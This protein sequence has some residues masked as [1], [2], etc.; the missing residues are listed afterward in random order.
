MSGHRHRQPAPA[1]PAL[2]RLDFADA[3]VLTV[4][5]YFFQ[6]FAHPHSESWVAAFTHALRLF[7]EDMAPRMALAT[8][9][10]VQSMR[11]ARRSCF[12]FSNPDCPHCAEVIGEA[13]RH[14]I[15]IFH[16]IAHARQSDAYAH[17][18]ILCEGNQVEP[19][20]SEFRAL[21]ALFGTPQADATKSR[22]TPAR[23]H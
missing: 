14:F 10:A 20:L 17:A 5:R 12:H 1:D 18:I 2:S 9:R 16:A 8:L 13:E 6:G 7:D 22:A 23:L 4:A 15:G 11:E 21:A 19:L 3:A